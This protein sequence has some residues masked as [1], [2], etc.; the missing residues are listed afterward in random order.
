MNDYICYNCKH[1]I[2]LKHSNSAIYCNCYLSHL[3]Y[4]NYQNV[5]Y[6]FINNILSVYIYPETNTSYL[7]YKVKHYKFNIIF[8]KEHLDELYDNPNKIIDYITYL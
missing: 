1:L 5:Y 2:N 4:Q 3:N 8:N 7:F 6:I